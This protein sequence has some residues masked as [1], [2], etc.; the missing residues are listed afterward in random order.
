MAEWM[1]GER[2]ARRKDVTR[3]VRSSGGGGG[4][5]IVRDMVAVLLRI[6]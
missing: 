6:M 2:F 1:C 3:F 4:I 5:C